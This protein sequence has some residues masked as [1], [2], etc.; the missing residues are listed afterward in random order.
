MRVVTG[1]RAVFPFSKNKRYE[2]KSISLVG[3]SYLHGWSLSQHVKGQSQLSPETVIN[4][5]RLAGKRIHVERIIGQVKTFQILK[6]ELHPNYWPIGGR[7]LF[8]CFATAKPE[9]IIVIL[10]LVISLI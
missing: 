8:V 9:S 3:S 1:Y 4:D 6:Q 2:F 7:I 5:R 10:L